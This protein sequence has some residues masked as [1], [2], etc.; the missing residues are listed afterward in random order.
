MK[1]ENADPKFVIEYVIIGRNI[2]RIRDSKR[3]T[4]ED[5]AT[6]LGIS[7][8]HYSNCERGKRK[9]SLLDL[10]GLCQLY[11][12]SMEEL[13]AGSTEGI[14]VAARPEDIK[15]C[16]NYSQWLGDIEAIQRGCTDEARGFMLDACRNIAILDKSRNHK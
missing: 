15:S 1:S 10:M 9:I 5:V 14:R 2:R 8:T 6:S 11:D 3:L 4:Q 13:L 7:T 12:V 16:N